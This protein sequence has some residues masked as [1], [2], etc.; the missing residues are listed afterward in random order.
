MG[1]RHRDR[2]GVDREGTERVAERAGE[3]GGQVF[4]IRGRRHPCRRRFPVLGLELP[5]DL[6]ATAVPQNAAFA[7]VL[8]FTAFTLSE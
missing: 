6:Q 1:A 3:A 5:G 8:M 4:A 7:L 2:G